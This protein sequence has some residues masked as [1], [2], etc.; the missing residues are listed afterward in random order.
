MHGFL[1]IRDR[2]RQDHELHR[3]VWAVYRAVSAVEFRR[4]M[5]Q[6]QQ[7]CGTQT[8]KTGVGPMLAKFGKRTEDYAVAYEHP[9]CRRTSNMVDRPMNRLCRLIYAGRGL[10]RHQRSS[11]LRLEG[12]ALLLN[13][14][15]YAPRN[16]QQRDIV[17]PDIS[18][19]GRT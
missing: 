18:S 12:W 7:C 14:R 17:S 10:H 13:L 11:E 16:N 3:R 19:A 8:W 9:G 5:G 15:P 4:L 6:F 2:S 1:K